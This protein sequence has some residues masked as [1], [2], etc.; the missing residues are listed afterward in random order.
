MGDVNTFVKTALIHMGWDKYGPT[1]RI[2]IFK[3]GDF[4]VALCIDID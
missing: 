4:P 3:T 1:L 2:T